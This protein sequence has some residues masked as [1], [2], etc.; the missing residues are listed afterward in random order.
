MEELRDEVGDDH[1]LHVNSGAVGNS[2]HLVEEPLGNVLALLPNDALDDSLGI[3]QL[4]ALDL[5]R[6]LLGLDLKEEAHAFADVVAEQGPVLKAHFVRLARDVEHAGAVNFFEE[7]GPAA[8]DRLC[9]GL[10]HRSRAC[11]N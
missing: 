4:H 3:E 2:A 10:H 7:P 1:I 9:F 5:E 8:G 6:D 11:A